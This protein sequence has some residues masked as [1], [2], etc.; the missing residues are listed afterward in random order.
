MS[1]DIKKLVFIIYL[2][3]CFKYKQKKRNFMNRKFIL[4]AVTAIILSLIY[5]NVSDSNQNT[6]SLSKSDYMYNNELSKKF[7]SG[8]SI[9]DIGD[10]VIIEQKPNEATVIIDKE[11]LDDIIVFLNNTNS[12]E[13]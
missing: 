6:Y 2:Y 12:L 11:E 7:K 10:L 3:L 5:L 8:I 13:E 1:I 9:Q 4:F